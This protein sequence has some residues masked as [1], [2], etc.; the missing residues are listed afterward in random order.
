MRKYL[1]ISSFLAA[2]DQAVKLVILERYQGIPT[3]IIPGIIRFDPVQNENLNWIASMANIKMPVYAMI[4]IQVLLAF[5]LIVFFSYQRFTSPDNHRLISIG[6]C[7]A[8]SGIL[9][10]FIDV[11][12][13]GGSLDYI[14]FLNWFVFDMKD[15]FLH[16]GSIFIV[17]WLNSCAYKDKSKEGVTFTT[18]LKSRLRK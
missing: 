17:I 2:L 11:V 9:C 5:V 7:A 1:V 4:A 15:M 16:I 8:F 10:S 13:W 14:G 18:W 3:V 12:F 6:F